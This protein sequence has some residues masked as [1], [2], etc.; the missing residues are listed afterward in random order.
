MALNMRIEAT[1]TVEVPEDLA[2]DLMEAYE[3]LA[4]LPQAR[5]VTVDF[6]DGT[7]EE[8][9][10]AAKQFVRQ[11]S[12]WATEQGLRFARKGDAKGNPTRVSFRIYEPRNVSAE[13]AAE[14]AEAE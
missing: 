9:V 6:E 7:E 12:T 13:P 5:Q 8:N 1:N 2:A 14:N 3:A 11:A 10:K 4:K